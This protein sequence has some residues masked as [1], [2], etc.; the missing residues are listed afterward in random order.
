M[1]KRKTNLLKLL[2]GVIIMHVA[3]NVV[4]RNL[5]NVII[6]KMKI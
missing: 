1:F 5:L 3:E 2:E 4:I 6:I